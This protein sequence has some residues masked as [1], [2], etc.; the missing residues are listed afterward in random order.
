MVVIAPATKRDTTGIAKVRDK[1][2]GIFGGYQA[3]Q[4][5]LIRGN[6]LDESLVEARSVDLIVTSPPYNVG[7]D[8]GDADDTISYDE[9]L[10]F[11]Q[12]W[13]ANC[14]Q[15]AKI[16]GRLCVNV[17]L[18]KN[19]QGKAPLSADIT[20]IAMEVGWK[21]HATIIWNEG[22]ISRKTAWGSWRSPSAPHVI[23]PVETIIVLYKEEWRRGNQ[24]TA[25]IT[26]DDFKSWVGGVW[27]FSGESGKRLGHKAPFPRELPKRCIQLF[28]FKEDTVLDP[29]V[30]SGTTMIEAIRGGRKAV[31]IELSADYCD[32]TRKRVLKECEVELRL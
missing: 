2:S 25:T 28:S 23:A 30:G 12:Q 26:G 7:K 20:R 1:Y 10:K 9:Y 19:K 14:Y 27:S 3:S 31:G 17:S 15:W 6:A 29:F 24:G 21:Y 22:N 11:S 8:Y 32:L 18:D 16:G 13:L 5:K 4:H